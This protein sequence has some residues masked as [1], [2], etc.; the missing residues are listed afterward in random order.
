MFG[1]AENNS[2][3]ETKKKKKKKEH[4]FSFQKL[5]P[6]LNVINHF[7]ILSFS[8]SNRRRRRPFSTVAHFY[9]PNV[10]QIFFFRS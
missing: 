8:F 10:R 3:I 4:F 7:L 2:Q 5:F 9:K 6:F 1:A